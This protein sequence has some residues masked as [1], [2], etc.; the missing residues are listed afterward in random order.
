[1][2]LQQIR[3]VSW[4]AASNAIEN[5]QMGYERFQSGA[6]AATERKIRRV[7]NFEKDADARLNKWK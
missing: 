5:V 3:P 6:I 1:M 2:N 7:V 4:I